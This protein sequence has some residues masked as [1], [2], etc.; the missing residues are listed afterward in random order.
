MQGVFVGRLTFAV[1]LP[2]CSLADQHEVDSFFIMFL[3][4]SQSK[5]DSTSEIMNQMKG[6]LFLTF[7]CQIFCLSTGKMDQSISKEYS[8]KNDLRSRE[9]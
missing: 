8:I 3:F 9:T 4:C 1:T 2:H 7:M 6:S 5:I